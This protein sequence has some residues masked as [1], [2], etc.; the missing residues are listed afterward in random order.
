MEGFYIGYM[1]LAFAMREVLAVN[2]SKIFA[3]ILIL[4]LNCFALGSECSEV[5]PLQA[6]SAALA[7]QLADPTQIQSRGLAAG[8]ESGAQA[9]EGT[10]AEVLI[11]DC[12]AQIASGWGGEG[13]GTQLKMHK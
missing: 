3:V 10:A 12:Q 7:P 11:S 5:T 2:S 8:G 4:Y 1:C 13:P 6:G 9:E